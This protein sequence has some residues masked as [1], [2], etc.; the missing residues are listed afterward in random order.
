MNYRGEM[1]DDW[2]PAKVTDTDAVG[3]VGV[4]AFEE[5]AVQGDYTLA[6]KVGGRVGTLL[7][8]AV[9][10]SGGPFAAGDL[11]LVRTA[12]TA[13]GLLW[14]C[15]P[16]GD[17]CCGFWA[18]YYS[19]RNATRTDGAVGGNDTLMSGD[20]LPLAAPGTYAS[21][22]LRGTLIKVPSGSGAIRLTGAVSAEWGVY[23]ALPSG[24]FGANRGVY[25]EF[26]VGPTDAAGTF[27]GVYNNYRRVLAAGI[28]SDSTGYGAWP[29]GLSG[30]L[31]LAQ[32]SLFGWANGATIDI[33]VGERYAGGAVDPADHY[34]ALWVRA[35]AFGSAS[36]A[37][38]TG[39]VLITGI[40]LGGTYLYAEKVCCVG[41]AVPAPVLIP[42]PGPEPN[43]DDPPKAA[44]YADE[45]DT[46]AVYPGAG[47]GPATKPGGA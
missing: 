21:K 26:G 7:N 41:D 34:Y 12:K 17:S 15:I 42:G 31:A 44:D 47:T 22:V 10:V 8:P 33:V 18:D 29:R 36:P 5:Y 2:F 20:F 9:A 11:I 28:G 25:V 35:I 1:I 30:D 19:T 37:G 39:S 3:G 45:L 6:E 14:E 43:K 16:L 38:W 13:G 24:T 46:I 27:S 23:P 4:Y 40:G 32:G